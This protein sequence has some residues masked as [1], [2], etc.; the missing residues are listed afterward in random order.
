MGN[1]IEREERSALMRLARHEKRDERQQAAVLIRR[2]LQREGYLL[3]PA[4]TARRE[5]GGVFD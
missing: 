4:K 5:R 1:E 3:P 2:A